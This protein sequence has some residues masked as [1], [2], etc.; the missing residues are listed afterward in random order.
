MEKT[1]NI[2]LKKEQ[3]FE[4]YL[5]V[6]KIRFSYNSEN[7][8]ENLSFSLPKKGLMQVVGPNGAGKTTLF[9]L[10]L[11]LYNPKEGKIIVNGEDITG[12]P[13][14]AS[15]YFSYVPQLIIS[16]KSLN[17]PISAREFLEWELAFEERWP[18]FK[19]NNNI[20]D[21]IKNTLKFV[22]LEETAFEKDMRE[23][24]GGQKQ[25][26]FIAKALLKDKPVMLLDEPFSS[27]DP[28]TRIDLAEIIVKLSRE[29]LVIIT[30]HDPNLL[31]KNTNYML[32]L[33]RNYYTF[34][35]LENVYKIDVLRNIYGGTAI[36]VGDKHLHI[37]DEGCKP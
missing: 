1:E 34:G 4:K 24:S 11:G 3:T 6:E 21:R 10:L 20:T 9:K 36:E 18:R 12:N 25:K 19:I 28:A 29:K 31:I 37:C 26:V 8:F 17:F 33:S 5:L 27:I 13:R 14:L 23:L 35:K 32:L 22:R 2:I 15:K 30:S 16:S 7:I